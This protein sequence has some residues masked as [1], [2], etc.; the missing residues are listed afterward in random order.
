MAFP[1]GSTATRGNSASPALSVSTNVG[2][3][4]PLPTWYMFDRMLLRGPICSGQTTTPSPLGAI[5]I[6]GQPTAFAWESTGVGRS[7]PKLGRNRLAQ[8]VN[9]M[10]P[11]CIHAANAFPLE[12]TPTCGQSAS[13]FSNSIGTASPQPGPGTNCLARMFQWTPS[14]C[15]HTTIA[16]PLGSTAT[17]G[18]RAS[19]ALSVSI[20]VA[21]PQ[22]PPGVN[23][24]AQM[25]SR[26][27]SNR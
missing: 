11:D 13:K 10:P 7:Q 15:S 8:M 18:T 1:L 24:L 22:P 6:A 9:P 3:P 25:L 20:N 19:P 12:S 2:I 27:P 17:C 14:D 5:V 23:R 21:V 4:Q 26:M 16:F